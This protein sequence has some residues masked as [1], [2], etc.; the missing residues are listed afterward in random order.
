MGPTECLVGSR[1]LPVED[2]RRV[3]KQV[4]MRMAPDGPRW[5]LLSTEPPYRP[6]NIANPFGLAAERNLWPGLEFLLPRSSGNK[7]WLAVR[8][9]FGPF[10]LRPVRWLEVEGRLAAVF[11]FERKFGPKHPI[12]KC[13]CPQTV[14]SGR[15]AGEYV[16]LPGGRLLHAVIET[17]LIRR[18]LPGGAV[19]HGGQTTARH[20]FEVRLVE[21]CEA[22]VLPTTRSKRM[23]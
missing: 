23:P 12:P 17:E 15:I 3:T 21:A 11:R 1:C 13:S 20:T 19:R 14:T 2:R 9:R 5:K 6:R 22:P 7:T 8:T 4:E 18:H 10:E 16:V